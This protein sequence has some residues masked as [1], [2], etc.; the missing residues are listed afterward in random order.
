[1]GLYCDVDVCV[2]KNVFLFLLPTCL[3]GHRSEFRVVR[4]L[5]IEIPRSLGTV[6]TSWNLPMHVFLK[7]CKC[8]GN[9]ISALVGY[10]RS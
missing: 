1:M 3:F 8:K 10:T 7:N 9:L 6:V 5:D 2:V 4:P